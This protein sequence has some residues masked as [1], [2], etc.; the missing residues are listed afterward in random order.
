MA[1]TEKHKGPEGSG[2]TLHLTFDDCGNVIDWIVVMPA[3][4]TTK[5]ATTEQLV[6]TLMTRGYRVVL[7]R[8]AK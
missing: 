5:D 7:E 2:E 8:P 1:H 4:D 3:R 6:E